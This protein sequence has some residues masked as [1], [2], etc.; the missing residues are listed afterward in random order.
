MGAYE[1]K[2]DPGS[3]RIRRHIRDV[4]Q[5]G[6]PIW[7][8]GLGAQLLAGALGARVPRAKRRRFPTGGAQPRSRPGLVFGDAPSSFPTLQWHGDSLDLR[9]DA[10]LLA[11]SPAY[12]KQ[13]FRYERA[14]ALQSISR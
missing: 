7:G 4:A 6:H 13:A 3:S 11:S 9:K 12:P 14:Y 1:E 10:T 5:A 8:V 2:P